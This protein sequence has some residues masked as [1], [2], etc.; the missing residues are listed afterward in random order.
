[1]KVSFYCTLC[2]QTV[3][4]AKQ[5]LRMQPLLTSKPSFAFTSFKLHFTTP[6]A[7]R[8]SGLLSAKFFTNFLPKHPPCALTRRMFKIKIKG[9]FLFFTETVGF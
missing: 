3:T 6:Q 8:A 9:G 1:M 2:E 5:F 4:F 7:G